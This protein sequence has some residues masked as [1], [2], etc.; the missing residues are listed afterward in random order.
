MQLGVGQE[1]LAPGPVEAR[2]H[3]GDEV[4]RLAYPHPARQHRH[5]G[6]EADIVH[7]FIA[8]AARVLAQHPQLALERGQA[9]DGLQCGGLA[10]AVG[11][12]Q[13]DD[14]AGTDLEIGAGHGDLVLV[15]LAQAAGG[16]NRPGTGVGSVGVVGSDNVHQWFPVGLSRSARD[17]PRR[18]M[19]SATAGHSSRRKRSRS[20][21]RN[22]REASSVTNMPSPRRFSTRPSS[23]S[24]W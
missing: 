5:V 17:R 15:S 11:A 10:G 8:L 18:W 24:S 4:D 7:Q 20:L 16:D 23:A 14:A 3:A 1:A 21:L 22:C 13:A 19:R 12:D 2:M 6:D 9:E